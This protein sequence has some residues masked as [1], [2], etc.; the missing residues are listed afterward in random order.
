MVREA[1]L[2]K[3]AF[4]IP[5]VTEQDHHGFPSFRIGTKVLATLPESNVLN[6]MIDPA[7]VSAVVALYS[8][9]CSELW[10]GKSI[11]G[12]QVALAKADPAQVKRLL[13]S[14]WERKAPQRLVRQHASSTAQ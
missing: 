8:N 5:E 13:T 14:V 10:W 9:C 11:R 6:V 1:Q 2:R 7:D 12:V 4:A 3:I